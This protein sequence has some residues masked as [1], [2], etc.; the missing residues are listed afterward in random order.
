MLPP[1]R[2]LDGGRPGADGEPC[3]LA[4]DCAG[5]TC[6]PDAEGALMCTSACRKG[7]EPCS[8]RGDC[9]DPLTFDCL[10]LGG[11]PV[12]AELIH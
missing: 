9:C 8:A 6:A 1:K 2:C 7:G 5:G 3:A 11:A 4:A 12:C 10:Y